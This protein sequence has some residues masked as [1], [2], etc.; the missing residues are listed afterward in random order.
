MVAKYR[1]SP[2]AGPEVSLTPRRTAE[3]KARVLACRERACRST[4]STVA[5]I[6]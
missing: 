3:V 4:S 2:E 6:S 5:V 1:G